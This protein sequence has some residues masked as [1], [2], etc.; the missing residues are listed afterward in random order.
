[1]KERIIGAFMD[2]SSTMGFY[3]VTMDELASRA[4]MSKRTIYR[5]FRSKEEIIEAVLDEFMNKV[6][7]GIGQV[8]AKENKPADI[9]AG[10]VLY[11]TQT[12]PTFI[13]PLVL[14]D[15]KVHY[16]EFWQKVDRF[17]IEKIQ[18]F[19]QFMVNGNNKEE[20]RDIDPRI[21]TAAF[22]ASIQAVI[23]PVFI[24]DNDLTFGEA[25]KQL[26]ELF[27]HGFLK[28]K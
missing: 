13:N 19:I 24:L 9:I 4:G 25:V 16:P 28:E 8:I 10:I 11:I 22:I 23:N 6:A 20:L 14:N 5:Y 21:F 7:G 3:N 2:L 1:M 17:R 15:L 12:A 18:G 26:V 27:M